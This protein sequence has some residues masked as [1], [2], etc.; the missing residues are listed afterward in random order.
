MAQ[1]DGNLPTVREGG[2]WA[3]P[4]DPPV[5]PVALG[6]SVESKGGSDVKDDDFPPKVGQANVLTMEIHR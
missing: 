5:V 1:Q 4:S 3:Q 6:I 2:F